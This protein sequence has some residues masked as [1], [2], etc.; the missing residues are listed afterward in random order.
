MQTFL[1]ITDIKPL[2]K[3]IRI[4]AQG[5][6]ISGVR[7][8]TGDWNTFRE[9]VRSMNKNIGIGEPPYLRI[10]SD[11]SISADCTITDSL[12]ASKFLTRTYKGLKLECDEFGTVQ[13]VSAYDRPEDDSVTKS[14]RIIA[15]RDMM[16]FQKTSEHDFKPDAS[17][18]STMMAQIMD[19]LRS[20]IAEQLSD[21][22]L[23]SMNAKQVADVVERLVRQALAARGFATDDKGYTDSVGNPR[24]PKPMVLG[25]G[26]TPD[27][28]KFWQTFGIQFPVQKAA[29]VSGEEIHKLAHESAAKAVEYHALQNGD[30]GKAL[31]TRLGRE[32][33]IAKAVQAPGG[34]TRALLKSDSNP[35]WSSDTTRDGSTPSQ[36]VKATSIDDLVKRLSGHASRQLEYADDDTDIAKHMTTGHTGVHDALAK[37]IN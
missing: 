9:N 27:E 34:D 17:A 11:G 12:S 20:E 30:I 33:R 10:N 24:K 26:M 22:N 32:D 16:Q 28:M 36:F 19:A 14:D 5:P 15:K 3:G 29:P 21:D 31:L 18:D 4:T 37:I 25:E 8:M 7:M 6:G 2:E 1:H 23:S 35:R 13:C